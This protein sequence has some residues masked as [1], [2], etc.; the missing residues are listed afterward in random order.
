MNTRKASIVGSTGL[1]G[2]YCLQALLDD[3]VYSEVITLQRKPVITPHSK[4]KEVINAFDATLEKTLSTIDAQDVF[5]CL[6]TTIKKAG[7]QEAFREID[8]S[9]VLRV[10]HIMRRQGAEQFIVISAMGAD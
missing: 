7:S 6:G 1:T 3:P 10:A 2:G 4:L 9:L 5:C 8:Y